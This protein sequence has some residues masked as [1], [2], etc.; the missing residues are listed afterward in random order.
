M[1]SILRLWPGKG[2]VLLALLT[3]CYALGEHMGT[4][5]SRPASVIT[6]APISEKAVA[7]TFDDG[8]TPKWTP[9]ILAVLNA[10]HVKAT[11]FVIGSQARKYST[12]LA[13]E[14]KDG[15][16]IGNHGALHKRL[17]NRDPAF[18]RA[19]VETAATDIMAAG[20]PKPRFY[21]MPAGVYDAAALRVLGQLGYTVIGWSVDPQDWRHR[22]TAEEMLAI[23]QREVGPGAIIIFHDGT[24]GSAATVA[25]TKMVIATLK[26]DGYRFVT[27]GQL[28]ALVKGRL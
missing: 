28:L 21:R 14:V 20:A 9:Q 13:E 27:V 17:T 5:A 25:A 2:V 19:E 15:M 4:A 12:L 16:E 1:S 24:N 6:Q 22:F 10:A 23:V 26:R 11:F 8:P 7:L 3:A 18:I